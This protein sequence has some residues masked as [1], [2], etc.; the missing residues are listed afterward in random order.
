VFGFFNQLR[1]ELCLSA[2]LSR[3]V[4]LTAK[5]AEQRGFHIRIPVIDRTI[6]LGCCGIAAA[7]EILAGDKVD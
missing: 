5:Q 6:V 1:V 3:L 7:P 4:E 2:A